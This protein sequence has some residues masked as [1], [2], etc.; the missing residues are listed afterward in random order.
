MSVTIDIPMP[1][2][3][4]ECR[5][6]SWEAGWREYICT[7]L[8]IPIMEHGRLGGCPIEELK[9]EEDDKKGSD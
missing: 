5:L 7:P 2:T 8:G 4:A 1:K 6:K 9:E 3:C